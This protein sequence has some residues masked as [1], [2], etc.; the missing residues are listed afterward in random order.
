LHPARHQLQLLL[1]IQGL[2]CVKVSNFGIHIP[3]EEGTDAVKI[4][5]VVSIPKKVAI[6]THGETLCKR[7]ERDFSNLQFL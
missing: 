4:H 6:R 1:R 7:G 3:V 2:L 5:K